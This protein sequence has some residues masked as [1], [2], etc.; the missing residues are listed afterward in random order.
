MELIHTLGIAIDPSAAKSGSVQ[1]SAALNQVGQAARATEMSALGATKGLSG[2]GTATA[3]HVRS[4]LSTGAPIG[5]GPKKEAH[6]SFVIRT[7]LDS[8][9]DSLSCALEQDVITFSFVKMNDRTHVRLEILLRSFAF[10]YRH[11]L[12]VALLALLFRLA[13]SRIEGSETER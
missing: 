3:K 12:S 2:L 11:R 4:R 1:A 9:P 8:P 6:R 13:D 7:L 10:I 5:A